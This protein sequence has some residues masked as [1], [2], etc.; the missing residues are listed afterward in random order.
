ML[1][2]VV[3]VV[4]ARSAEPD[5]RWPGGTVQQ[6]RE[7]V[8]GVRFRQMREIDGSRAAL[9]FLRKE[10]E[11]D[12]RSEV[13]AYLGWMMLFS[14][15]WGYPEMADEPRGLRLV[16][17]AAREGSLVGRDVWARAKGY[18]M[19]GRAEPKLVMQQ[20]AEA[21]EGGS[22]HAMARLG[23]Y[24]AIG[25]DGRSDGA[26]ADRFARRAAELGQTFGLVQI[27]DAYAEGKIGGQPDIPRAMDYYFEAGC[28]ADP[29]AWTKLG[30]LA[31]KDTPG[32]KLLL[33][34]GYV[35]EANRAAWIAPTRVREHVAVLTTMAGERADAL[36]ELGRAHLV[37]E[38]A[39]RDH[40]VARD[41]FVRAA[42]QGNRDARVF[43]AMMKLRGWDE[44]ARVTEALA[45]LQALAEDGV[46]EAANYLGYL[47]YWGTKEVG[48]L[49]KDEAKAFEY[50]RGA[51]EKGHPFAL[52]NL[53]FCYEDGIGTPKNFGLAAKVFWQAHLRGYPDGKTRVRRLMAFIK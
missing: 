17:E 10:F 39:K 12:P 1:I 23:Y 36:V 35:R 49:V 44:T 48:G 26:A 42:K 45:D 41:C 21:S 11:R 27:G 37:G 30:A 29:E 32:A 3:G 13:K 18:Q 50:V 43:L 15:G 6:I 22:P 31:K 24:Y 34:I 14:K 40:K 19:G 2:A 46:A 9:D 25:Y 33:S 53:G 20:L 51:A 8:F 5:L 47:Y 4:A 7:D 52:L 38:Y 28:H 16:E